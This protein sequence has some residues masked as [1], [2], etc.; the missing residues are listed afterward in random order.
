MTGTNVLNPHLPEF[1]RFLYATVGE[2]RNG[3]IVTVLSTLARLNLDPWKEAAEL[4]SLGREA[5]QARLGLL[6]S[7]FRDVPALGID[8]ASIARALTLLLPEYVARSSTPGLSSMT[9]G[10]L[11][12]SRAIWA[13]VAVVV[14]LL[15]MIFAGARSGE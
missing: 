10:Q 6:L 3:S 2:D 12:S 15:Q 13:V 14:I 9:K 8:H 1:E 4:A 11:V 7:R 5:A